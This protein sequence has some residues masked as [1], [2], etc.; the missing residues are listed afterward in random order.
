MDLPILDVFIEKLLASWDGW[1]RGDPWSQDQIAARIGE[2]WALP[3]A[4]R[5]TQPGK[6]RRALRTIVRARK[7]YRL[8]RQPLADDCS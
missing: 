5:L 7:V 6:R 1:K 2:V 8:Q 3:P 4:Y